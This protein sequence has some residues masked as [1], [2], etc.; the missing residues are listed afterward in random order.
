MTVV[1]APR[2][3]NI[4]DQRSEHISRMCS[5]SET[6]QKT[7]IDLA[8]ETQKKLDDLQAKVSK[9]EKDLVET[10][11]QNSQRKKDEIYHVSLERTKQEKERIA[12]MSQQAFDEI[13]SDIDNIVDLALKKVGYTK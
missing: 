5:E 4:L 10:L 9:A 7:A 12:Q 11:K 8:E 13:S 3:K 6:T 1:A 2:L